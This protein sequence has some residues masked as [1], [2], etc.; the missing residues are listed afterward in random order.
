MAV[1]PL[2][3]EAV[4]TPSFMDKPARETVEAERQRKE[5]R[6]HEHRAALMRSQSELRILA[7]HTAMQINASVEVH[8]SERLCCSTSILA[9]HVIPS[10]RP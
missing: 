5:R 3:L 9:H 2:A 4:G 10:H 1:T 6:V 8:V 7:A